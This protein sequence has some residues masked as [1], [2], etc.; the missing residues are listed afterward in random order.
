MR[1]EPLCMLHSVSIHCLR[2]HAGAPAMLVPSLTSLTRPC[3]LL[4]SAT[5]GRWATKPA[6]PRHPPSV[7]SGE[8]SSGHPPALE[9]H[10]LLVST[11][12]SGCVC[13]ACSYVCPL[14]VLEPNDECT[15]PLVLYISANEKRHGDVT[16]TS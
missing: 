10:T 9:L 3:D 2:C 11:A 13:S 5:A 8:W 16:P 14:A 6:Q 15:F 4:Q 12:I 1:I 7:G